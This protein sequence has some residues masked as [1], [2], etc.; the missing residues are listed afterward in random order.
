MRRDLLVTDSQVEE[1]KRE[2]AAYA[3][4]EHFTMG[5]IYVEQP[6]SWLAAFEALAQSINR[7][8]V[9]A[10]VL[11]SLLHFVGIGMP[12]D[13]RGWFEETTGARVLV[14]NP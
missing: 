14:L 10:V 2:M 3:E 5:H 6:D 4:V 13:R 9:T 8:D 7:Y 12:T 11:P 1:L